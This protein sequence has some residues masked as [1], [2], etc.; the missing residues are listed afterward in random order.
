ML[1]GGLYLH[2]NHQQ[3]GVVISLLVG[4]VMI[5]GALY[6]VHVLF[7]LVCNGHGFNTPLQHKPKKNLVQPTSPVPEAVL[8]VHGVL[9]CLC[10][11]SL[12]MQWSWVQHPLAAQTKKKPS[13]ANLTCA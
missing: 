4:F 6:S 10:L 11:L 9:L 12:E 3:R 7:S 5:H 2:H 1:P 8:P 13:A